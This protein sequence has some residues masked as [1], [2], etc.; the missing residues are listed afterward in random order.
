MIN[1]IRY[2]S[3]PNPLGDRCA[4]GSFR[5]TRLS[6]EIKNESAVQAQK[7]E[8][9]LETKFRDKL[10]TL[11]D[12]LVKAANEKLKSELCSDLEKL[13]KRQLVLAVVTVVLI[14]VLSLIT[15]LTKF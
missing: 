12:E 15:L 4:L 9:N 5:N 2:K 8:A 10:G 7:V 6:E 13:R 11:A 3:E 14:G 1:N